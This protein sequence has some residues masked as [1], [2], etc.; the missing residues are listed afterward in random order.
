MILV[1][2]RYEWTGHLDLPGPKLVAAVMQE[3]TAV[4]LGQSKFFLNREILM[5]WIIV[6]KGGGTG[7]NGI[8]VLFIKAWIFRGEIS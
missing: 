1:W 7:S 3:A 4:W 6:G 2:F 8:H 5:G